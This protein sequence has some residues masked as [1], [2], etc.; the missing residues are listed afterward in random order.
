MKTLKSLLIVLVLSLAG[1]EVA[2]A[3]KMKEASIKLNIVIEEQK[4]GK[5]LVGF[6]KKENETVI[7]NIYDSEGYKVYRE[8]VRKGTVMLK[9]FDLSNMPNDEYSYEVTNYRYSEEKVIEN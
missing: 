5:V 3:G 6:E 2:K 4:T 9:R 7:I 8:T 1:A